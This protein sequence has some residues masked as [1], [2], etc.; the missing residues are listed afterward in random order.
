MTPA[1]QDAPRSA[2]KDAH[3]VV[4][5]VGLHTVRSVRTECGVVIVR[6]DIWRQLEVYEH[7]DDAINCLTCASEVDD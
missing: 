7:S 4:H 2:W 3:G 1:W 6:G 5:F